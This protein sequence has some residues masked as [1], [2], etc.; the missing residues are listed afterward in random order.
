HEL[1][2]DEE[3]FNILHKAKITG[4]SF[5]MMTENKFI[6]AR[7]AFGPPIILAKEWG[8]SSIIDIPQFEPVTHK[9]EGDNSS[10]CFCVEDVKRKLENMVT[11]LKS[12]TKDRI[13]V[14]PQF[15]VSGIN[16]YGCETSPTK[17]EGIVKHHAMQGFV[18]NTTYFSRTKIKIDELDYDGNFR[19][20]YW[21]LGRSSSSPAKKKQ[22]IEEYFKK[23]DSI[24]VSTGISM[25]EILEFT[26]K[27]DKQ[28]Q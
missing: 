21:H 7:I 20:N 9:L 22:R 3:D 11:A 16:Y 5:L 25:E 14:S 24:S 10:L 23:E 15:G 27:I 2:L 13:R 1:K 17:N 8:Y 18:Q 26:S 28:K 19:N 6:K 12:N 4:Q